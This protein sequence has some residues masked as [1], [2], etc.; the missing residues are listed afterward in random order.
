MLA[1]LFDVF[2][3]D[4][5][6]VI[7]IDHEALPH[8]A[9]SLTRL[10]SQG[11]HIRFL[12]NNPEPTRQQLLARLARIGITASIEEMITCG[13]ATA[14]YLSQQKLQTA[15]V[16]GSPELALELQAEGIETDGDT[17]QAVVVG[18]HSTVSHH[19]MKMAAR[20][21]VQGAQFIATNADAWYPTATGP[22]PATGA[23]VGAIQAACHK[24]PFIIGKPFPTMFKEALS[25]FDASARVVMIGDNPATDILGAHQV[26]IHAI[27]RTD[28]ATQVPHF[29]SAY[30][31]RRPDTIIHDLSDLFKPHLPL[32]PRPPQSFAWPEQV[33]AGVAAVIFNDNGQV[34]L[35]HRQDNGLWGLPSGHIEPGETVEEAIIREVLEESGLQ[36]RVSHLIGVYSDPAS[37]VFVYPTGAITHFITTCLRCEIIGGHLQG[38]GQ[39]IIA[40]RFF[41][42]DKLPQ[43]LLP[44]HPRWLMDA[45]ANAERAFIR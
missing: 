43:S 25:D 2:L 3:C 27:L 15:Y 18:S 31:L 38:D 7:Y 17:P 23:I 42:V 29:P 36:V 37:Q 21:I 32:S 35:V 45:Q 24:R 13:R 16:V 14:L 34:L 1:E 11:K 20:F 22:A 30:D 33:A 40:A 5:D 10:R 8:T 26:G 9:S 28:N 4:L 39:E 41:D 6:G 12:T 19:D 44:M